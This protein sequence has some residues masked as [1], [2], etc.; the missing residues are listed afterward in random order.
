MNVE[1]LLSLEWFM[2]EI[3]VTLKTL[4]NLFLIISFSNA[5]GRQLRCVNF[6]VK[7]LFKVRIKQKTL[8]KFQYK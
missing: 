8:E 5:R 3:W 2:K 1:N 6:E 7:K 4:K